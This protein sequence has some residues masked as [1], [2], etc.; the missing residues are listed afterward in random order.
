MFD[1]SKLVGAPKI[2]NTYN[3]FSLD[4]IPPEEQ[5]AHTRRMADLIVSIM[6]Q[7]VSHDQASKLLDEVMIELTKQ[8][9]S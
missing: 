6:D 5:E 8:A 2:S 9:S 1:L 4:G 3:P 7:P